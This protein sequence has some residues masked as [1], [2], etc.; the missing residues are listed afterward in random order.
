MAGWTTDAS[1]ATT[2]FW[3]NA[4]VYFLLTDRFANGDPS[5]DAAYGRARDGDPLRSFE[6]GDLRGVIQKLDEGYSRD[7][8]VDAIWTT[9]VI[10]QV[11]QPFQEY[12]RS[13]AFHG[14]WPRDWTA[15]DEAFGTE[16][17]FAELVRKA[18]AQNIRVIVDVMIN[19]AGPPIGE[20]DP[21]WPRD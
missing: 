19:H 5:N 4:T 2:P 10:R 17:E 13:Y 9:P 18:H 1:A 14:Y 8:G 3:R 16:A 21:T 20:D 6:G 11:R 7:L 12:G 15:V